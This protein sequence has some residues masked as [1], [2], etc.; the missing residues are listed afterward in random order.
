MERYRQRR[1]RPAYPGRM[2]AL[3]P[4]PRAA[5]TKRVSES[6]PLVTPFRRHYEHCRALDV[7]RQLHECADH[8]Q[9]PDVLLME[10]FE[11]YHLVE[12][13][14]SPGGR[15]RPDANDGDELVLEPFYESLE[16][17]VHGGG[18]EPE[19]LVCVSGSMSPLPEDRHPALSRR[20]LDYLGYRAGE[21]PRLVLGVAQAS[22]EDTPY[23]LLLRALNCFAELSP[24][25]R[26]VQLGREVIR[27]RIP[28]DVVFDLHVG[29]T[30][31][32]PGESW[33]ALIELTRDLA[34]LFKRQVAG[35]PQVADPL[36]RI[37]CVA[38]EAGGA[39]GIVA[40]ERIWSV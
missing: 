35:Q 14:W 30:D 38:I 23:V 11:S 29:I 40:M 16:L 5:D 25:L 34:E 36:G 17:S 3:G 26:V 21:P 32:E 10:F 4:G 27:G 37:E 15:L 6:E 7:E 2:A 13:S 9:H 22:K 33:L 1:G 28:E 18:G 39:G 31:P 8:L 12:R 24:P 20:G 19:R